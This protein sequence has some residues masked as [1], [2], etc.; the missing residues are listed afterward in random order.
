MY[1][2]F[3]GIDGAGKSTQ[4]EI[5]KKWLEDNGL[6]V[7]TLV[8]PTDSEIGVLIRKILKRPDAATDR[9]QKVLGLLF[10][11]DRMLIMDKL[12]DDKKI[13]LSDRSFISSLAYQEP[14][15]WIGSLNKYVKKPDLVL[16]L[17]VDIK[18]SALR[19]SGEDEFENKEFLT[20]VRDNYLDII[21]EFNHEIINANNGINKVSSDVKK[22]IASKVGLCR[23]CI[24]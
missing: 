7:E 2:I 18:N 19:F 22:A 11:A 10:A 20:K 1:I 3:E 21:K 4:I 13:F 14:Q 5:I 17:D 9:M 16:L 6:E 8:E 24:E 15:D 23:D 12:E